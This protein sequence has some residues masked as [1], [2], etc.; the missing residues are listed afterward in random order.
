MHG[1]KIG[2]NFRRKLDECEM[3]RLVRVESLEEA[4]QAYR[5]G[6]HALVVAGKKPAPAPQPTVQY[7]YPP[8]M[9]QGQPPAPRPAAPPAPP[10]PPADDLSDIDIQLR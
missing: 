8:P 10:P 9:P 7:T 4:L 3:P 2:E 1:S 6:A 5:E